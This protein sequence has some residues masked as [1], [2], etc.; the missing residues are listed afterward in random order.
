MNEA[1]YF[2]Q[3]YWFIF[4]AES[5]KVYWIENRVNETILSINEIENSN[6]YSFPIPSKKLIYLKN[7]ANIDIQQLTIF[8]INGTKLI[9]QKQDF[10]NINISQLSS[11]IY[12]LKLKTDLGEFTK[13]IIKE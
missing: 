10:D 5:T 9:V 6:I 3:K 2:N 4:G 8:N 7:T 12:I 13:K 11:G 1:P